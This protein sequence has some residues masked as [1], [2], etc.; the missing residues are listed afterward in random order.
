MRLPLR[1][2]EGDEDRAEV[3]NC[4]IKAVPLCLWHPRL[5]VGL[6]AED[7][8]DKTFTSM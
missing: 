5:G 4:R 6:R 2:G 7:G 8:R 1:K 3:R